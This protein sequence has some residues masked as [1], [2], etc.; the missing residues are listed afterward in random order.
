MRNFA[1]FFTMKAR[2]WLICGSVKK[3]EKKEIGDIFNNKENFLVEKIA[4]SL[5]NT[6]LTKFGSGR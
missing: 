4:Y 6:L 3:K 1:Q 2:G 5:C